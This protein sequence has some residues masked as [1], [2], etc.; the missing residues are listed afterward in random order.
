MFNE[1]SGIPVTRNLLLKM[2]VNAMEA[3]LFPAACFG[4]L[5]LYADFVRFNASGRETLAFDQWLHQGL[6]HG[7]SQ[8]GAQ[9]ESV[10]ENAPEYRL[11]FLP[12]NAGRFLVGL[13]RPSRD[14]SN[15]KYP[16][17]VSVLVDRPRYAD[18][19][20]PLAPALFM[21]FFSQASQLVDRAAAGLDMQE[22]GQQTEA[23][24]VASLDDLANLKMGY[25]QYLTR[26]TLQTFLSGSLG[27]FDGQKTKL[28][29]A[30]LTES[31]LPLRKHSASRFALGLRFPLSADESTID[32][33]A[34]FW[35]QAALVMSGGLSIIPV[36][37]WT[38]D[39]G[40]HRSYLFL[41]FRQPSPKIFLQ[42]VQPDLPSDGI[43][44]LDE[45]EQTML[46]RMDE[47]LG[48][49]L[50]HLLEDGD[51]TLNEFLERLPQL[52]HR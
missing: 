3:V 11:V 36:M 49:D 20:G 1:R 10:F 28:L 34:C 22:L 24:S 41:F 18:T 15:R 13:L 51:Q 35:V 33:Q 32:H 7:R 37:F 25:S 48:P 9:W 46:S 12:E 8:F 27:A 19:D 44:N 39:K 5:P 2:R 6:F 50:R 45:E 16:F 38:P 31:V 42:L 43:C 47:V 52:V 4:K 29:F 26:T 23:L 30:N 21:D 14:K 40:A 17:S